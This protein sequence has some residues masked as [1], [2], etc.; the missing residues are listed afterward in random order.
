MQTKNR[1]GDQLAR[2]AVRVTFPP[3]E[4]VSDEKWR[5]AFEDFD[6]EAYRNKKEEPNVE[7]SSGDAD[8][9]ETGDAGSGIGAVEPDEP[10]TR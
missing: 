6:P 7:A 2:G 3:P 4:K 8:V 9:Q 1:G 5:Q 10:Q